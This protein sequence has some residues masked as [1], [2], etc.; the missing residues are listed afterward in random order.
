[1]AVRIRCINKAGGDH[2][3][4]HEAI[5]HYGWINESSNE[6]GKDDRPTMVAWVEKGG[7][8]YVGTGSSKAYCQVRQ[9]AR[10]TKFLQTV[11]DGRWSNN[12]LSLDECK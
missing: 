5:S 11:S 2:Q 8:A 7:V 6:T 1:M 3:D 12:L 9:S 10:G 4:P